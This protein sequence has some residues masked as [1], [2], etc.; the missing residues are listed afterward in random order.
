MLDGRGYQD[1]TGDLTPPRRARYHCAKP[2]CINSITITDSWVKI[3]IMQ[4][5]FQTYFDSPLGKIILTANKTA[6][7]GLGFND[8]V[9]SKRKVQDQ[10][11]MNKDNT[12]LIQTKAWLE[13]YFAGE[14]PDPNNILL[15]VCGTDFQNA[16]WRLLTD[17]PY[18]Q[19]MT[20][21]EIA[22]KIAE[23][24]GKSDMAAQAVGN[25]IGRNP[26]PIIIPCHRV[27]GSSGNLTG[28]TGGLDRKRYLLGLEQ[29]PTSSPYP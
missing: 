13:S 17:I 15:D 20:Y 1:R 11:I 18:G 29:S 22:R 23:Q 9:D 2:R 16:V 24:L 26:I 7:T 8:Q 19:T 5:L 25:A 28:Y 3:D 4:L 27:I 12:V 21:G 10:A 14:N 6:L